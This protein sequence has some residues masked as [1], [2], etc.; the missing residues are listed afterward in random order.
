MVISNELEEKLTQL[1]MHQKVA[2]GFRKRKEELADH[3]LFPRSDS[4]SE[5]IPKRPAK[6]VEVPRKKPTRHFS[7]VD[8]PELVRNEQGEWIRKEE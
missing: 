3:S 1:K 8:Q 6:Q 2:E 4:F 5:S 7:E